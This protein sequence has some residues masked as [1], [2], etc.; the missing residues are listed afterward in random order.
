MTVSRV[1]TGNGYVSSE[2]RRKVERVIARLG[3]SPNRLARSLKGA[4]TRTIG[5][6]LPDLG[7]PFAAD[8]A[9]GVEE[10]LLAQGYYPFVVIARG[11]SKREEAAI[12]GF[13][14]HRVAGAVLA[15][16]CSSLDRDA[17]AGIAR[18]RFPVVVVGPEFGGEGI[19]HVIASY[20]RGGFEATGHLIAAGR[21][22]IAFLG[23]SA[24]EPRPLLR[25][26]GYLDALGE[27][28][29]RAE[30]SLAVAPE[31]VAP[32]KPVAWMSHH[33]GYECMNRLLDLSKPP[34]AVFARNDY[35]ATGALRAMRERGVRV[36]D[37]IALVGF[38]N[39]VC[40]AYS[41]PPLTTVNQF[42]FEQGKK[43][44]D[45]L[46]QRIESTRRRE[47]REER[48]PCELVV[49]ESSTLKAMA[50]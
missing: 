17:L 36:P 5:V 19:D 24:D 50:A 38:D 14:D 47:P 18:K 10:V 13:I 29:L 44:A 46:L 30:R 45:L 12:Q 26:Q 11:G 3:Y 7:N 4:S 23:S 22:R 15:T 31:K 2:L 43:A 35:A 16:R 40:A 20:R 39:V 21:R 1:V 27:H 9:Q 48:F 34:D 49:R 37:D 33:D 28:G 25:F 8:L 6:L 32:E 41:S 42:S